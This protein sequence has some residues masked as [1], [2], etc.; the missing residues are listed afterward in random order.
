MSFHLKIPDNI[1]TGFAWSATVVTWYF[2]FKADRTERKDFDFSLVTTFF[3][4]FLLLAPAMIRYGGDIYAGW[5]AIASWH[6]WALELYENEY[7]PIDAAYP[8]LIPSLLAFFYK[9][10]GTAAV[11]WNVKL[12][13]F[14]LPFVALIVLL[15]LYREKKDTTF[16]WFGILLYP[17]L[18]S[19]KLFYGYVDMPVMVMGALV[20]IVL[21]AAE[22]E[23]DEKAFR[24]YI[25]TALFLAGLTSITKQAGAVFLLFVWLYIVLNV[26][27]ISDKKKVFFVGTFSLLYL[28]SFLIFYYRH[29]HYGIVGNIG[30]LKNISMEKVSQTDDFAEY[31]DYLWRQF[32]SY[33]TAPPLLR[34]LSV[35]LHD[36]IL[37]PILIGLA[38][39]LYIFKPLRAYR[40]VGFLSA[41][42]FILGTIVW[43]RYFSYDDRNSYWVKSF[44]ILF[45]GVNFSY[46]TKRYR[47]ILTNKAVFFIAFLFVLIYLA[48][49]GDNYTIRKQRKY[50]SQLG[51]PNVAQLIRDILTTSEP[52]TNVYTTD[53]ILRYNTILFPYKKR[54]VPLLDIYYFSDY[55][56]H[57]CSSGEY[58]LFRRKDV[59]HD[60]WR[61]VEKAEKAGYLVYVDNREKALLFTA[62]ADENVSKTLFKHKSFVVQLKQN[63]V[64]LDAIVHTDFYRYHKGTGLTIRG[65]GIVEGAK[66]DDTQKF[67]VLKNASH[68]FVVKTDLRIRKDVTKA[69]HAKNLDKAGFEGKIYFDDFP[70]GIYDIYLLLVDSD[71]EVWHMGLIKRAVKI[72]SVK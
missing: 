26:K 12:L 15:T 9:L 29:T 25:Y 38:Y 54:V 32:F 19:S 61:Y 14:V 37:T 10:Q 67:I 48:A 42:F 59:S 22:T 60:N 36:F 50:Q 23:T 53:H 27:R 17:Y 34:S 57:N 24:H 16:V 3:I 33:P 21:Y 18:I 5:D 68:I 49:I 51:D 44:F 58:F 56:E 35:P 66:T 63:P 70:R 65:W 41:I 20:L 39:V 31:F 62:Y 46:V 11:W 2:V 13:L 52:C 72:G 8:L 28:A 4:A 71:E 43:I 45:A 47:K 40:S 7:K 69:F 1:L 55:L 6:R 30:Y 64:R